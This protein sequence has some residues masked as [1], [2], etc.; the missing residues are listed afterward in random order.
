[1]LQDIGTSKFQ[2][3][4]DSKPYFYYIKED[5]LYRSTDIIEATSHDCQLLS[6]EQVNHIA[7]M[8]KIY[9]F[10]KYYPINESL[11]KYKNFRV[12]ASIIT[13]SDKIFNEING[14]VCFSEL[15]E[16]YNDLNQNFKELCNIDS[17]LI[18]SFTQLKELLHNRSIT[19]SQLMDFSKNS[20]IKTKIRIHRYY[21]HM[22][23][24][25]DIKCKQIDHYFYLPNYIRGKLYR[26]PKFKSLAK[27]LNFNWV[28]VKE[29]KQDLIDKL[30]SSTQTKVPLSLVH[31][32]LLLLQ[33]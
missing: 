10:F 7:G 33:E 19:V 16:L 27:L 11:K 28:S 1:M 29:S 20:I 3:S 18:K 14:Y 6:N 21:S 2:E 17:T 23:L 9:E 26:Q 13:M 12:N 31:T 32:V 5:C 25:I 15:V 8:Y 30:K 24:G 4:K 22:S